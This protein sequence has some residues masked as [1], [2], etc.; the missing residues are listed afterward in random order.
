V[1]GELAC[2]FPGREHVPTLTA[3]CAVKMGHP[4]RGHGCPRNSRLG[5]RRYGF[6]WEAKTKTSQWWDSRHLLFHNS[7]EELV[8]NK[9]FSQNHLELVG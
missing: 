1:E 6:D 9:Y 8:R 4:E 3:K 5:S 2:P 7:N